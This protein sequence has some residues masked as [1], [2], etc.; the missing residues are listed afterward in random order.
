MSR[1]GS[2]LLAAALLTLLPACSMFEKKDERACPRIE[3]VGDLSRL[4][5]FQDGPGRDLS[6]IVYMARVDD[7]KSGCKYDKTG[8]TIDLMVSL[9]GERGRAG[10]G[11][12]AAKTD[13]TYFVAV[14]DR[15]QNIIDKPIFTSQF[16]FADKNVASINDEF[17]LRI[18]LSPT[19][20]AS[21][22]TI[23]VGFQLTPEEI[24]FNERNRT[25]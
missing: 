6:D 2:C 12:G 19:T 1:R 3:V 25:N 17:Q 10:A 15:A 9:L 24:D 16:D 23:I 20:S 8:V 11:A 5:K 7:V 13:A 22:H 4:V 18:A 14:T 21:D